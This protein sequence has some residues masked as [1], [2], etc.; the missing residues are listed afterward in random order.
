MKHPE[1]KGYPGVCLYD[2]IVIFAPVEE[3]HL[4]AKILKLYMSTANG[5]VCPG[6]RILRFGVDTEFNVGWGTHPADQETHENFE[7]PDWKPTPQELQPLEDWVDM[8]L[9]TFDADPDLSVYNVWDFDKYS[10]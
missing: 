4:W 7:N 8:M 5:W 1:L 10:H 3:R 9:S 6:R 2:S